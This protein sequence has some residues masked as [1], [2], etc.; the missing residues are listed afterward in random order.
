[1][2]RIFTQ[3]KEKFKNISLTLE[4]EVYSDLKIRVAKGNLSKFANEI[5][6]EYL[7]NKKKEKLASEYVSAQKSSNTREIAK[8]LE[9]SFDYEN[10]NR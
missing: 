10:D 9:D 3:A 8:S 7:K 6:K 5:F 1:M 4:P 2:K